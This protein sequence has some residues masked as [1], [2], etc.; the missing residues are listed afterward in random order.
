MSK[1]RIVV[2]V[3]ASVIVIAVSTFATIKLFDAITE[4]NMGI[5]N[6]KFETEA[7]GSVI[8]VHRISE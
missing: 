2:V 6:S 4:H 5:V 1:L 7:A 8:V 3:C